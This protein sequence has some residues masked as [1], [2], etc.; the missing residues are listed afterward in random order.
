M[1]DIL[2][3]YIENTNLTNEIYKYLITMNTKQLK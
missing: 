2:I 1:Y 3:K